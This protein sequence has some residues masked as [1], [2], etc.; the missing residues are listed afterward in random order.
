MKKLSLL[1]LTVLSLLSV[2]CF[3]D[4]VVI[5]HPSNTV[6]MNKKHISRIFLGKSKKFPGGQS[7]VPIANDES[8]AVT[9]DFNDKVLGRNASQLKAHWSRLVFTGKGTPPKEVGNDQDVIDLVSKNPNLIGYVDSANLTDGV[10]AVAT[11]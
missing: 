3:A 2:S 4:V 1:L 5:V 7:A 8:A 6:E 10:K 11:F 9:S